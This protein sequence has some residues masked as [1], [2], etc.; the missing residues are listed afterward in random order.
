[1]SVRCC[2]TTFAAALP[3]SMALTL[4]LAFLNFPVRS[5]LAIMCALTTL[6]LRHSSSG[7]PKVT[8]RPIARMCDCF[9]SLSAPCSSCST[10]SKVARCVSTFVWALCGASGAEAASA[11]V[12]RDAT[13]DSYCGRRFF[14]ILRR[15]GARASAASHMAVKCG[16]ASWDSSSSSSV[17]VSFFGTRVKRFLNLLP[18]VSRSSSSSSS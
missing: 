17:S 14:S 1:M 9:K 6:R 2:A 5:C 4:S 13:K 10:R 7:S 12:F 3:F 8:R 15:M 11:A 16:P 18:G